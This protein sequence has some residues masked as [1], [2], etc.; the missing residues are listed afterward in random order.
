VFTT[1][2]YNY[3]TCAGRRPGCFEARGAA[4]RPLGAYFAHQ[5]ML[6]AASVQAFHDLR[7]D[8]A[9]LGAPSSLV[10]AAT[11]AAADEV[12]HARTCARLARHHDGRWHKPPA[13][14]APRRTAA[15][16]A[17]DNAVEGCVRETYGAAVAA[18]QARTAGD[19]RVRRAMSTIARDEAAHADLAWRVQRWLAP[20]LDASTQSRV[21]DY[22]RA[23]RSELF[24][25]SNREPVAGAGLPSAATAR[26]L[27]SALDASLWHQLV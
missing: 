7:A 16:L 9:A 2:I 5:A 21:R 4:G 17:E 11:R 1:V 20:P 18:Y 26:H 25:S 3:D 6:E 13:I 19:R 15:A 24:A 8:L 27:L 12:R 10:A 14:P 22:A 23:A